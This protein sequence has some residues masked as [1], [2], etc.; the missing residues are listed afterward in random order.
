MITFISSLSAKTIR[1]FSC[2]VILAIVSLSSCKKEE[3]TAPTGAYI[4]F[5][6][7][8]PTLGTFNVYFDDNKVS[9]AALPFGGTISF[10]NYASGNHTVK[11][12]TATNA[13][14]VLTKQISL[15]AN[16]IHSVYL[17]D[18]EANLD[19]LVDVDDAS[20]TS[21][22]KAFVKF[23]NLSPDAPALNLDI[24]GGA[25]VVKDKPYKTASPYLQVDP[26]TYDFDIK[27]SAT[28]TV[29]TSLTG[30]EMAAG[31]FYTIISRGL[32]TPGVNDQPFGAQSIVNQ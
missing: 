18:K 3:T 23:I 27:D 24:K 12:T 22:T 32:L 19:L 4:R 11:Y 9:T 10:A 8:S 14:A 1:F 6:N 30:V 28:G 31:R 2:I 21:T 25:N 26:K 16:K 20:L 7:A 5:I 17:I 29:K 15:T 13:N